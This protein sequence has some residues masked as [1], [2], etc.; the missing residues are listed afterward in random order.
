MYFAGFVDTY[1]LRNAK[2]EVVGVVCCGLKESVENSLGQTLPTDS[3]CRVLGLTRRPGVV[4]VQC[5]SEVNDEH[6]FS[7]TNE[8][9]ETLL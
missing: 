2:T 1:L 4:F 6:L 8:V 3:S 9:R 5:N 7:W